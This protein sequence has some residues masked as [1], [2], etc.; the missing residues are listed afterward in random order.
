M[1]A[2]LVLC[3]AAQTSP[4]GK[5]HI[6][7]AG[8]RWCGPV[9]AGHSVVAFIATQ[10]AEIGAQHDLVLE[11]IDQDGR[12][13]VMASPE[14]PIT[15]RSAGSIV[16]QPPADHR[17]GQEVDYTFI[18]NVGAG[19]PLQPGGTYVWQLWINGDTHEDWRHTFYVRALPDS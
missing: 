7:G 12:P 17:A 16:A 19:L 5:T 2:T 4:D 6:L 10:G 13:V 11:L 14:G 8:W 1:R 9:V 3:D 15:V 18:G